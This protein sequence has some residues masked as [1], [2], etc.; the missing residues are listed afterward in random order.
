ML[1]VDKTGTLT[2]NRMA[3]A[4]LAVDGQLLDTG[5]LPGGELPEAYHELLEY[6]VLASEIEPHDPMEQAFHHYARTHLADTGHLHPA[7]SLAREYELSPAL[8]AMSHLWR[9][10]GGDDDVVAAKGA[11]E[12]IAELCHLPDAARAPDRGRDAAGRPR[13]ARAGHRQGAAQPAA[14]VA[15]ATA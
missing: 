3:L 12:A 8:L 2:Q 1:C 5:R 4:A 9:Q 15:G 13:P 10:G 11:P 14:G 6:A 7:W